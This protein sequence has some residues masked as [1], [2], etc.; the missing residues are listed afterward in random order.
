M[1]SKNKILTVDETLP[2]SKKWRSC[3]RE[4][5]AD[6]AL[7]AKRIQEVI[8]VSTSAGAA[9]LTDT[10]RIHLSFKFVFNACTRLGRRVHTCRP[11]CLAV[12]PIQE[13]WPNIAIVRTIVQAG[14]RQ[15]TR[16][17]I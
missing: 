13:G 4:L 5:V 2:P 15:R 14:N 12:P 6:N 10:V 16:K 3:V 11:L 17:G 8:N 7:S 9:G 1:L